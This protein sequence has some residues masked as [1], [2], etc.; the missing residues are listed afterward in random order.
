MP[1][2]YLQ[3]AHERPKANHRRWWGGQCVAI[4][5][6]G[7]NL[8]DKP[9]GRENY[10]VDDMTDDVAALVEALGHKRCL[11]RPAL[12]LPCPALTCLVLSQC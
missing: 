5:M 1:R 9:Q 10:L 4:D 11:P 7:Y 6:R 8:S 2:L 3:Q 12:T